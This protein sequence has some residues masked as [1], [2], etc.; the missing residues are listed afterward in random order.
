MKLKY[1]AAIATAVAM[2]PSM[3]VAPPATAADALDAAVTVPDRDGG[4]EADEEREKVG[5]QEGEVREVEGGEGSAEA[6]NAP[7]P[8]ANRP[9]PDATASEAPTGP[10]GEDPAAEAIPD[11]ELEGV[12]EEIVAG[13]DWAEFSVVIDN[14]HRDLEDWA[15]DMS[16]NSIEFFGDGESVR[17]QVRVDGEWRD[18][19]LLSPPEQ[20][21]KD[22]SLLP[23]FTIPTGRTVVPVR[24]RAGADAPLIEFFINPLVYDDHVQSDGSYWVATKIVAPSGEEPEEGSEPGSG[25]G[26]ESGEE[27]GVEPGGGPVEEPGDGKPGEAERPGSGG[28]FGGNGGA[29]GAGDATGPGTTRPGAAAVAPATGRS[30]AVGPGTGQGHAPGG[31]GAGASLAETGGGDMSGRLLGAGSASIALGAALAVAARR[32]RRPT[33]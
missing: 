9:A 7:A 19:R 6:G 15:L 8:E 13:G 33:A 29:D 14:A 17:V 3:L 10:H 18:A 26:E 20:D 25:E 4:G 31:A 2:A 21:D 16:L 22:L 1:M 23:T 27:P 5:A 24:I 11:V 28:Q 30:H 32:R 12:P